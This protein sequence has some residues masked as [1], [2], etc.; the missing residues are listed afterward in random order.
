MELSWF[1]LTLL[2]TVCKAF[3]FYKSN[4]EI[5]QEPE[6]FAN[7]SSNVTLTCQHDNSNH[8]R[9]FWYKQTKGSEGL[10]LL[11][12]SI[13]QN[14]IEIEA[15]FKTHKSKYAATRPEIKMSTLLI[16]KLETEDSALYYC[17]TMHV[18]CDSSASQAYFGNGTKLTVLERDI[19]KPEVEILKPSGT[20]TSCKQK[21]TLVCVAK[22]FYPDHVSITWTIGSKEIKD[23]VATDPYATQDEKTK[24]FSITSRLKVSKKE[25]KPQNTFRCTVRF[26]NET[27]VSINRHGEI[28]GIAGISLDIS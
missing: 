13:G 21:V 22:N 27:D 2:L 26:Y 10:S 12:F 7:G 1:I 4:G 9:L 6:I 28:N 23:D 25:F 14:Q 17:A 24:L 18:H 5:R 20:E 3:A 19:S 16:N 15:P 11:V 8:N